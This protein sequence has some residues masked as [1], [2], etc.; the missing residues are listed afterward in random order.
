[1]SAP[2]KIAGSVSTCRA[3]TIFSQGGEQRRPRFVAFTQRSL[4]P[5]TFDF[6]RRKTA[7]IST[8]GEKR[9]WSSGVTARS[10]SRRRSGSARRGRRSPRCRRSTTTAAARWRRARATASRAPARGG[11]KSARVERGE[12]VGAERTA[13]EIARLGREPAKARRRRRG[14]GER[15]RWL[16]RRRRWRT[17]RVGAPSLSAKAPAPQKRSATRFEPASARSANSPSRVSPASVAC[18]K[19]PGGNMTS[20]SPNATRGGR[21]SITTSP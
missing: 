3:P 18:R 19:P 4:R 20:A 9:N 2:A 1:M 7:A 16:R 8:W 5:R 21:R 6:G 12:V 17:L 15:A 10:E 13:E 11:S 14:A